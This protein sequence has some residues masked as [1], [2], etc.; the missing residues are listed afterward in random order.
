MDRFEYQIQCYID[1]IKEWTPYQK[2]GEVSLRDALTFLG[3]SR[4]YEAGIGRYTSLRLA[5]RPVVEWEPVQED[6]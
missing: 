2:R 1:D 6:T 3:E 4:V 5:R